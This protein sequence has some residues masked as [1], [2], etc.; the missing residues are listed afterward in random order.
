LVLV[1]SFET[2]IDGILDGWSKCYVMSSY[3]IECYLGSCRGRRPELQQV[4][5]VFSSSV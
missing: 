2:V 1:V 4:L 5:A 3:T